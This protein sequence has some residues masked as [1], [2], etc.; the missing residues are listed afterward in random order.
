L[1]IFCDK[2]INLCTNGTQNMPREKDFE[3][4][5]AHLADKE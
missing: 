5:C 4:N 2:K 3:R 1:G